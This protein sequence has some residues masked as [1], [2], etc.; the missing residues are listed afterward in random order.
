M[1]QTPSPSSLSLFLPVINLQDYIQSGRTIKAN[2]SL[3]FLGGYD[4]RAHVLDLR[5]GKSQLEVDHGASIESVWSF[6]SGTTLIT[7][8]QTYIRIWDVLA[9][10][11]L[12]ETISNHRQTITG[13]HSTENLWSFLFSAS[14]CVCV[15][16]SL[17]SFFSLFL[18]LRSLVFF[19]PSL[20][21]ILPL[22]P[23]WWCGFGGSTVT[24]HYLPFATFRHAIGY[25]ARVWS[26]T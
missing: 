5:S 23:K 7:A 2:P 12:L 1:S 14:T 4:H 25:G 10:G 3:L 24:A 19:W 22:R 26:D 21:T 9:G 20:G 8:G 13:E 11:K 16:L 15:S 17:F 6:N 18:F